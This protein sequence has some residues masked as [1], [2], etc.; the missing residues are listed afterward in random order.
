METNIYKQYKE[1]KKKHP[2]A[3][4]LLRTGD[5][6]VTFEDDAEVAHKV[7]GITISK[8]IKTGA[9]IAGFPYHALDTYLPKLIRAGPS[10][11][12]LKHQKQSKI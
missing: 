6:Y 5:F 7:L 4:I 10:V 8:N 2:D 9:K 11:T 3:V 1:L 12:R